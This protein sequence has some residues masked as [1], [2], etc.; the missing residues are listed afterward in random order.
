MGKA[1]LFQRLRVSSVVDLAATDNAG[2]T[3]ADWAAASGNRNAVEWLAAHAGPLTAS[4]PSRVYRFRGATFTS[5]GP[6]ALVLAVLC[7]H[8]ETVRFLIEREELPQVSNGGGLG[9]VHLLLATGL[10][11]EAF[12]SLPWSSKFARLDLPEEAIREVS[13]TFPGSVGAVGINA[14]VLSAVYAR[15]AQMKAFARWD[16]LGGAEMVRG[17]ILWAVLGG[18]I[19]HVLELLPPLLPRASIHRHAI[20]EAEGLVLA[21]GS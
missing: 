15:P 6:K 2:D 7:G 20:S 12:R 1:E 5:N 9:V 11:D 18:S 21:I 14:L 19:G 10:W 3:P 17:A 8:A 16:R 13:W 4:A